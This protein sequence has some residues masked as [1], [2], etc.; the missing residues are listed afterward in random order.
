MFSKSMPIMKAMIIN[1]KEFLT[2]RDMA[3]RL[4]KTPT[5]VKQ[6]LRTRGIKPVSKDAL[7]SFDAFEAIKDAPPP[8]RPRSPAVERAKDA[9][10]ELL[11]A[12]KTGNKREIALKKALYEKLILAATIDVGTDRIADEIDA[13]LEAD[14]KNVKRSRPRKPKPKTPENPC[15]P[16]AEPPQGSA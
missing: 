16:S 2:V 1:G 11:E 7:Y 10:N 4:G 13:A 8:G 12:L 5:A 3:G 9:F 14:E 15:P 6:L